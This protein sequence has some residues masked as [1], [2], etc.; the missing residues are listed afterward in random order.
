MSPRN[1]TRPL[2]FWCFASKSAFFEWQKSISE[3]KWT[4][5]PLVLAS[6]ITSFLL[7]TF[8][9]SH[10][11]STAAFAAG[12]FMAWGIGINLWTKLKCCSELIVFPHSDTKSAQGQCVARKKRKNSARV[13]LAAKSP[14]QE[15]VYVLSQI[16]GSTTQPQA[17][18]C[19][20]VAEQLDR[21]LKNLWGPRRQESS[22]AFHQ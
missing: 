12:I 14:S 13:Q 6:S 11:L 3:A 17:A 1:T 7:L 10:P 8:V 9:R 16:S 4:F 21:L 20:R 15:P 22:T 19:F 5:M 2:H 18:L